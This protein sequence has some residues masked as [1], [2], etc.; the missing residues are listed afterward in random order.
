MAEDATNTPL[1]ARAAHQAVIH[2]QQE[3]SDDLGVGIDQDVIDLVD[4]PGRGVLDRD[5]TVIDLGILDGPEDRHEIALG[6]RDDGRIA[7]LEDL[8][9]GDVAV[10]ARSAE[11]GDTGLV[12]FVI[13]QRVEILALA[14]DRTFKQ[15]VENRLDELGGKALLGTPL[16]GGSQDLAFAFAVP[17]RT[18]GPGLGLEDFLD[19]TGTPGH[20]VDQLLVDFTDGAADLVSR[21]VRCHAR[22]PFRQKKR[23]SPWG[24]P[25]LRCAVAHASRPPPPHGSRW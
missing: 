6:R 8:L 10:T 9:G 19:Q 20:G 22:H 17:D 11:I 13:A 14:P 1:P 2:A 12:E 3:F 18:A 4:R 23:A 21:H 25:W 15:G 16:H 7:A 5:D 24:R